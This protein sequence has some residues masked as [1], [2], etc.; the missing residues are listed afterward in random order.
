MLGPA[1]IALKGRWHIVRENWKLM[2]GYGLFAIV[3]PQIGHF[4]AVQYVQVSQGLLIQF[5][6]PIAI[7]IWLWIRRGERPSIRTVLGSLVAIGGL[8]L[9]LEVFAGGAAFDIRGVAWSIFAMVGNAAYFVFSAEN[10]I[11][12]PPIVLAAG[13]TTVATL[14]LGVVAVIGLLPFETSTA[15]ANYVGIDVPWWLP[16]VALGVLSSGMS[17]VT[18]IMGG[19]LLGA[20]LSS[21]V[22]L[23]EV[24]FATIL[25]AVLVAQL[26]AIGQ[27]VG[28]VLVLA[29][30]ILVKLGESPAAEGIAD[31]GKDFGAEALPPTRRARGARAEQ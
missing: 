27:M 19:R 26:P 14:G 29:G 3:M 7:V 18:G 8:L 13:G 10:R 20:R 15:P 2:V 24:L 22:G 11:G 28:A 23:A 30:V 9:V 4:N 21:F 6:A 16:I 12:L 25:A 17:Y 5:L 1:I 31:A